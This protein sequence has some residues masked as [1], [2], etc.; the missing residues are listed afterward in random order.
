MYEFAGHVDAV[1]QL[2]L[3]TRKTEA[4]WRMTSKSI[5]RALDFGA[6]VVSPLKLEPLAK[7]LEA[8]T[9]DICE[10]LT[11]R[12]PP[13]EDWTRMNMP[14]SLGVMGRTTRRSERAR[15]KTSCGTGRTTQSMMTERRPRLGL[16]DQ[17]LPDEGCAFGQRSAEEGT[18]PW[19]A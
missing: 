4:L 5:A 12:G 18:T 7:T 6:E 9:R 2:H 8:K 17:R 14:T 13:D 16:N 3:D 11:K 19:H 1:T 10:R 15:G